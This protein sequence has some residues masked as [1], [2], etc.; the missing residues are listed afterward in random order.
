MSLPHDLDQSV[1]PCLWHFEPFTRST[2]THSKRVL[3]STGSAPVLNYGAIE[4]VRSR[5][6]DRLRYDYVNASFD[7][8][9]CHM[10]S[11]IR[12][13]LLTII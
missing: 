12:S 7:G 11:P 8:Q 6:I 3:K 10:A 2:K 13:N 5:N 4:W 9:Y 1:S